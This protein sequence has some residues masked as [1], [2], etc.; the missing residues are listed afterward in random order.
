MTE[1][2]LEPYLRKIRI[3]KIK[4]HIPADS[5]L[6]DVGCGANAN[7]LQD[8]S[9]YISEGYGFDK[10]IGDKRI[11]NI[12]IKNADIEVQIPLEDR[13][14]DCVTMLA[15]LEHLSSPEKALSECV[16]ILRPNGILVLT[17]PAPRSKPLLEFLSF[18]LGIVSP[19]EIADH[20]HYYSKKELFD[21]FSGAGLTEIKCKSFEFGLNNI[22]MAFKRGSK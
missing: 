3:S 20:K 9:Y 22:A 8:I 5:I 1:E 7:F 2:L 19:A 11:S 21:L 16:R 18:N 4:K 17:T 15:V 10:K 12:Y 13:Y 14:V 6:C